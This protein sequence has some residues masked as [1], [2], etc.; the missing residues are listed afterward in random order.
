[1]QRLFLY[2][3]NIYKIHEILTRMFFRQEYNNI[4]KHMAIKAKC[5]KGRDEMELKKSIKWICFWVSM[6][7]I[8]NLVVLF[9]MGKDLALQ[10]TAGYLIELS[11]S[12]DNLFVFMTIFMGFG[13]RDKAQHR[14]LGY[15]I[16]GAIVLRF[17][18]IFFGLKL[19]SSFEWLLY[20]FGAILIVNGIKM[21]KGNEEETDPHDSKVIKFVSKILPMTMEF[22]GDRFMTRKNGR[23]L[24]TPLFAVL[25][26]VECSDIIFA[27][28]SVPAVFSVSTNLIVVYTSNIF[29]ILGLRQLYFVLAHLQERFKYVKYGVGLLLMFTGVKLLGV[30][31]NFHI[32]TAASIGIII[33][34]VVTSIIVS[35]LLS[36]EKN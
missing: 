36:K 34:V 2:V 26:L 32:S 3:G 19:V 27:I 29:A 9:T 7:A 12:V 5:R 28:D 23:L 35:I 15:G 31:F 14:V 20:I 10:F 8:T 1:M 4:K 21:M 16:M 22:D 24:F 6:A 13:I 17:I 25:C 33:T 18:F 30:M 11:L